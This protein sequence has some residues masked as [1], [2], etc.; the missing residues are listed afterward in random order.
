WLSFGAL[1]R[2]VTFC[3][4]VPVT[5]GYESIPQVSE[6]VADGTY[7]IHCTHESL[8]CMAHKIH[9]LHESRRCE[10]AGKRVHGV[11]V[12]MLR[13]HSGAYVNRGAAKQ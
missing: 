9:G 12:G 4:R 13:D 1:F 11:M 5:N 3:N 10:A 6:F 2:F 8:Q 7:E